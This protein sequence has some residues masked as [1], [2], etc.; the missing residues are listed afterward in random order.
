MTTTAVQTPHT[1]PHR[2]SNVVDE[3][4][5]VVPPF[6]EAPPRA[7]DANRVGVMRRIAAARLRHRGLEALIDDVMLI[8]PELITNALLHSGTT[9]IGLSLAVEGGF[10]R[11]AVC[12]G[13][14]GRCEFKAADDNAESGRGLMLIEA[15]AQ[16][17]GGSWGT[18]DGGAQT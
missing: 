16:E 7:E 1:V 10:L 13:M 12:D 6:G 2:A 18:S 14:P 11:I 8:V 3:R 5:K 9:E 4:F 15:M 17:H